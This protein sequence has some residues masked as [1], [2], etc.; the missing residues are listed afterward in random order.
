MS[1]TFQ[2]KLRGKV[3]HV[4]ADPDLVASNTANTRTGL[5]I[6]PDTTCIAHLRAA[7]TSSI[8]ISLLPV[9][10]SNGNAEGRELLSSLCQLAILQKRCF[11]FTLEERRKV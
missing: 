11:K 10:A 2:C 9:P 1:W 6:D 7:L 3:T 5:G 4:I 8:D